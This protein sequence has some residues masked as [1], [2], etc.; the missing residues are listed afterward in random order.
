MKKSRYLLAVLAVALAP[1]VGLAQLVIDPANSGTD[2]SI[3]GSGANANGHVELFINGVSAGSEQA[4]GSGNWTFTATVADDDVLTAIPARVWNFNTDGDAEGWFSP[5][6]TVTV[7]GGI[8]TITE[9]DGGNMT[10]AVNESNLVDPNV[11]RVLEVRY[12]YTGSVTAPGVVLTNNENEDGPFGPSWTPV[13]GPEFQTVLIDLTDRFNADGAL[14]P[15]DA[16][17][18]AVTA[19]GIGFNGTATGNTM[20]IDFIRLRETY[21]WDFAADGDAQ[22]WEAADTNTSVTGISNGALTAVAALDNVNIQLVPGFQNLN[23]SVFN[24]YNVRMTQFADDGL[25]PMQAGGL[26][27]FNNGWSGYTPQFIP[28]PGYDADYGNPILVNVDLSAEALWN[29]PIIAL[30]A[31][32]S[33][34]FAPEAGDSVDIDYIEFAPTSVIGDAE[35]VVVGAPA[36]NVHDWLLF[37]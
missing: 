31:A 28:V 23:P 26:A 14:D 12:R 2:V 24:R 5:D 11:L 17:S 22:G 4:D 30:N 10:F 19:V 9:V 16:W 20:E 34:M 25:Q 27:F 32:D 33:F 1:S 6:D 7:D 3:T 13:P 21:R 15:N 35:P 8:M 29:T 36:T 37:Q 18:G